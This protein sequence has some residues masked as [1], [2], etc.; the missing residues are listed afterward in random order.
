MKKKFSKK[1]LEYFTKGDPLYP[2]DDSKVK[3]LYEEK[4]KYLRFLGATDENIEQGDDLVPEEFWWHAC[5]LVA[6]LAQELIDEREKKYNHWMDFVESIEAEIK[7]LKK[8]N[9]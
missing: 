8:L 2:D 6:G 7:Q 5:D 1:E 3:R 9:K 4:E